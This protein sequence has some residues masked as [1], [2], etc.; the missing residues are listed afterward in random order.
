M[1]DLYRKYYDVVV[2][3]GGVSGATSAIA[4]GRQGASVLVVE[5]NGYLGGSLTGCGVGPMMTFHAGEKQ[6]IRGMMQE[7]VD[8]LTENGYSRGHVRDTTRYVSHVT[9]FDPEGLK[10]ILDQMTEEAGCHVLLHSFLGGVEMENGRISGL[11]VCNKDGLHTVHGSVYIDATGDGDIMAWSGCEYTR[12][13]PEDEA[14]QPMTMNMKY[15]NVDTKTLKDYV[16]G[17]LE[18]FPRL[19]HNLD[20]LNSDEPFALAGFNSVWGQAA[21]DGELSIPREDVL[22][23]ETIHPGEFIVNTTRILNADATSAQGL[24]NAEKIGRRQ[25]AELDAFLHSHAPGFEHAILEF[26]GPSVG[27]RGSRQLVGKYRI[28]AEDI[29]SGRQFDSRICLSGYPI[30]IHNPS[31]QGTETHYV[32]G[33]NSGGYYSIPYEIMVPKEVPNLLVPGRCASA[34][35]EAQASIR[36]TPSVGSMGQAAGI[37]ADM[38]VRENLPVGT[39]AV[40]KLQDTLRKQGALLEV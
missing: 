38:A 30:D 21:K 24:S 35:F 2:A 23:F 8:R 9:P 40:G 6:V 26:T 36:L 39:I 34:S 29:L 20:L 33:K 10:R 31:G 37:A 32:G 17:H 25:C 12:G 18:D 27:I 1:G 16:R 7:I 19:K 22:M 11:T 15:A 5:Q 13:R 14:P 4:A 28:T 3:G